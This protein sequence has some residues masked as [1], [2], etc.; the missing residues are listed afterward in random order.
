[1]IRRDVLLGLGAIALTRPARGQNLRGDEV[2]SKVLVEG[3]SWQPVSTGHGSSDGACADA[4]GGLWFA[5]AQKGGVHRIEPDGR[6]ALWWAGAPASLRISGIALGGDGR[7]HAATK[8]PRTQIVAI[9][10][11]SKKLTV[12][13]TG[14]VPNDLVV[15]RKG[16]VF[17]TDTERGQ[18]LS[19]VPRGKPRV[20]ASE[21]RGPNG[22][23]LSPDEGTLIVSEYRGDKAWAYRVESDGALRFGA[24]WIE[25]R[26]PVGRGDSG[27]DGSTTD[28][29]GRFYV[30]STL[31]VQMFDWTG[32]LGGVI[33]VPPGPPAVSVAFAG[34]GRAYLYICAGD[35]V[36]RRKT[37]VR[38][39]GAA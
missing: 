20:V 11:T 2:L 7:L 3:E 14:S 38:G 31:G 9:D 25:L 34:T 17:F 27:G 6:A 32:R 13:A 29:E 12:L 39:A 37:K 26:A 24:P 4:T 10:Q 1:M 28:A 5:D 33:A 23:A 36:W 21:L 30:T 18:V 35:K 19:V 8:A 22:L 16:V 15:T